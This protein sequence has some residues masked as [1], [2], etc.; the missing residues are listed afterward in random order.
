MNA[1]TATAP[2]VHAL[3]KAQEECTKGNV[4]FSKKKYNEALE[5]YDQAITLNPK[6]FQ[7]YFNKATC[8]NS[9]KMYADAIEHFDKAIQI[10]ANFFQVYFDKAISLFESNEYEEAVVCFDKSIEL[11][12]NNPRAL[13]YKALSYCIFLHFLSKFNYNLSRSFNTNRRTKQT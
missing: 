13:F 4:L 11:K 8:F 12:P 5:C 9:M 1:A 7:A 6:Y 3:L 10:N 2:S